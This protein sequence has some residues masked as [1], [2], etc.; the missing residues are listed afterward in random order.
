[1]ASSAST[2]FEISV[3]TAI[4]PTTSPSASVIGLVPRRACRT[5]PSFLRKENSWCSD[6][7]F[8]R[9]LK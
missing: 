9:R 7:P 5:D 1:M 3:T 2:R 8:I 4:P 6:T